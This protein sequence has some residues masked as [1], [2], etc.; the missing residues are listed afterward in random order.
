MGWVLCASQCS[1]GPPQKHCL[2]PTGSN[3]TRSPLPCF[4]PLPS[5]KPKQGS[6]VCFLPGTLQEEVENP[7]S[8][9]VDHVLSGRSTKPT[10][11]R[12]G[13]RRAGAHPWSSK[14]IKGCVTRCLQG[15]QCRKWQE[16]LFAPQPF[17]VHASWQTTFRVLL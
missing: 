1:P 17:S 16:A 15:V 7:G 3:W 12:G 14:T 11:I 2:F 4:F 6:H 9:L 8:F 13:G 5:G 10:G